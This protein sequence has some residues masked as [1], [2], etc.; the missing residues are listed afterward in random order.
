MIS[1]VYTGSKIIYYRNGVKC[2]EDS[3][4]I[5]QIYDSPQPVSL[6]GSSNPTFGGAL[7]EFSL[8]SSDLNSYQI[9]R[10]YQESQHGKNQGQSIPVLVYHQV[11]SNANV[12]DKIT[13]T[14]FER[15]MNY[16][17]QNGFTPITVEDYL[18]W[19][20]G[21]FN[22]P[23]KPVI[24]FFDD[25]WMSVYKNALPIMDKYGFKGNIAI[26]TDYA[27]G[28]RGGPSYMHWPELRKLKE[29]GWGMVSHSETHTYMLK[30]SEKDFRKQ[31][32][33]SKKII[34]D[35]LGTAPNSFVF[36]FSN[37]NT[38]YAKICGEYY[39]LCWTSGSAVE[40]PLYSYKYTDGKT[41]LG[42]RRINIRSDTSFSSFKNLFSKESSVLVNLQMDEGSGKILYDSSG[43]RNNANLN[44]G[45]SWKKE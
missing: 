40:Q 42:L 33:D 20:N 18:N 7:D 26:V 2:D 11:E 8:Y 34:K 1:I 27:S 36:P 45:V 22:L 12:F 44:G 32:D 9:S 3:S 10:L 6:G 30:L 38:T 25:G 43:N 14:E 21:H 23:A 13:I 37:A 4:S 17:H 19:R 35:N 24:I 41:Y 31:L 39:S 16:L 5:N 15:Q 29:K 28:I